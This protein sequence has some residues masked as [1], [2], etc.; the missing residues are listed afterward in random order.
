ME[1]RC[2]NFGNFYMSS[3]QQGI[4]AAHGQMEMFN[5]YAAPLHAIGKDQGSCKAMLFEWSLNYKT[6]ICLNAGDNAGML[7]LIAFL[8][9]ED[10]YFPFATFCE[11]EDAMGGMMTN[12]SIVLS[13]KIFG[14]AE[15]MR[16]RELVWGDVKSDGTILPISTTEEFD[17]YGTFTEFEFEL[18][19][20]LRGM[21][22]AR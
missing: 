6:M 20:R 19:N 1:L 13:E 8:R 4:Q 2:Y 12:I 10:N 17:M 7:D 15:K 5:K 14:V 11:S 21:G 3:I 18:V 22:L 9:D 16:R